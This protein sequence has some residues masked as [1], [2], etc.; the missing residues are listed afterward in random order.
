MRVMGGVLHWTAEVKR[1]IHPSN[2]RL[3]RSSPPRR[4]GERL[5]LQDQVAVV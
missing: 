1:Q 3:L 2:G 5:P 4:Q